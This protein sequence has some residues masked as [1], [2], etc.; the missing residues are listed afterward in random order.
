MK[1][2][3]TE[4]EIRSERIQESIELQVKLIREAKYCFVAKEIGKC[5]YYTTN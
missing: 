4:S 1:L 3:D 2:I 5:T